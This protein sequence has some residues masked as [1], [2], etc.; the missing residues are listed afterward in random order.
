MTSYWFAQI[1]E[2]ICLN[3][4]M[5][6]GHTYPSSFFLQ[7]SPKSYLTFFFLL[8]IEDG[9]VFIS[10]VIQSQIM[11]PTFAQAFSGWDQPQVC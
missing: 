9:A 10:F 1:S 8:L 6:P 4:Q 11:G 7:M 2:P 5:T 3:L